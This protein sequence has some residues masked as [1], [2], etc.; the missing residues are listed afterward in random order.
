[1]E[2]V[3]EYDVKDLSHIALCEET[4][5]SDTGQQKNFLH[6]LLARQ[7]ESCDDVIWTFDNL[8]KIQA[9]IQEQKDKNLVSLMQYDETGRAREDLSRS[10]FRTLSEL[11]KHQH[12]RYKEMQSM[13]C[14]WPMGLNKEGRY[15][16]WVRAAIKSKIVFYKT[17]WFSIGRVGIF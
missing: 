3:P 7:V 9:S 17:D 4:I 1:M 5:D 6:F 2:E 14:H 12:W 15:R 8:E 13:S 11:R 16:W 10:F